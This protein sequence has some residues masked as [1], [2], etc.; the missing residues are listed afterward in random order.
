M[1]VPFLVVAL[2]VGLSSCAVRSTRSGNQDWNGTIEV[3]AP[4]G[5]APQ[6][7]VR[8]VFRRQVV[9]AV[10]AGDGDL[11]IPRL[12]E[13]MM[14]EPNNLAVRLELAS[15]FQRMG[16]PELAIEHYRLALEK[17]PDDERVHIELARILRTRGSV[18]EASRL[19]DGFVERHA[20]ASAELWSWTGILRDE[21]NRL[22]EAETAHRKAL[23]G[24]RPQAYLH[25]NLGQ[26]LL[27]QGKLAQ[28][29]AQFQ[30]ALRLDPRMQVAR[31][32]LGIAMAKDRSLAVSHLQSVSNPA[33][34]HNNLAAI[35][36]E[37]GDYEGARMELNLA[38]SYQ[39]GNAAALRNLALVS[40]LDGQP[41]RA[42]RTGRDIDSE[43]A[44][45]W[46]KA[47][48]VLEKIFLAP[49]PSP[50]Q[51]GSETAQKPSG[52]PLDDARSSAGALNGKEP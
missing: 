3:K 10:D 12:R 29:A 38:L 49:E 1:K 20:E 52:K 50:G 5:K 11:E 26:N 47:A 2:T 45:M 17:F 27:L 36:I 24:T 40:E 30:D 7:A 21:M 51:P 9:N 44:S 33:V 28:A 46:R 35:L 19:L 31:N 25:N 13:R 41:A 39:P 23:E 18:V 15:R 48:D 4:E 14:A 32:N 22:S 43:K 16:F 37:Q 6:S 42:Q 34:A 8:E